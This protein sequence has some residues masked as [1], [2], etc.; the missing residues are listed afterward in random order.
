MPRKYTPV[1]KVCLECGE[2]F[3]T[4]ERNPAVL[5]CND[6]CKQR[7]RAK[8]RGFLVEHLI[9]CPECGKEFTS[10]N[11]TSKWCSD[12]CRKENHRK[13]YTPKKPKPQKPCVVCGEMFTPRFN[14]RSKY[15]SKKCNRVADNQKRN[16]KKEYLKKAFKRNPDY[17]LLEER[18]VECGVCGKVI[19][20]PHTSQ[21]RCIGRCQ[22]IAANQSSA[23][24]KKKRLE[25]KVY[26]MNERVRKRILHNK[27]RISKGYV[28]RGAMR[29]LGY[30]IQELIEH[31]IERDYPNGLPEDWADGTKYHIDHIESTYDALHSKEDITMEDVI[32]HNR[33]EN[34]RLVPALENMQK[35]RK[36]GV[37]W[38]STDAD[39]AS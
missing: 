14:E 4:G 12:E 25:D 37:D 2:T 3:N 10:T 23:K 31:W 30:S 26:Q 19:E 8:M 6:V 9:E 33:M 11:P 35:G 39:G 13:R 36:S 1:D 34:L 18:V 38:R 24:H 20:N 29:H 17:K 32:H 21:K 5:T 28:P 15:C 16:Y 7:R 22:R 27:Q